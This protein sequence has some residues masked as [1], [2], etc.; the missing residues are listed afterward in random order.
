MAP[1][2]TVVGLRTKVI[3][4]DRRVERTITSDRVSTVRTMP[5]AACVP[6]PIAGVELDARKAIVATS[7]AAV[8]LMARSGQGSSDRSLA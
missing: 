8:R 1:S 4:L 5:R 3:S 2:R 7:A 6:G